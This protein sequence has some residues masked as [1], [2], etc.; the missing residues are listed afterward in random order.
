LPTLTG[1]HYG[2]IVASLSRIWA[3]CALLGVLA[4]PSLASGVESIDIYADYADNGVIDEAYGA[5]DLRA[6]LDRARDDVS[7]NRFADAVQ[8]ALDHDLL[9]TS[10]P[11]AGRV[12]GARSLA[13]GESELPVPRHPDETDGA[14][15]S[16]QVL[17][18]LAG[19]LVLAGAG[20][21]VYR[22]ARR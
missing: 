11:A 13:D 3:V 7:Y 21:S 12:G 14:P 1:A 19:G 10:A 20:S 9:G 2:R 17:L 4:V 6:A 8:D 22:R 5:A 16:F 15:W 18:V